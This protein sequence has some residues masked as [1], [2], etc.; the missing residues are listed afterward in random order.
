MSTTVPTI[1][2]AADRIDTIILEFI[3]S[4]PVKLFVFVYQSIEMSICGIVFSLP[5][6]SKFKNSSYKKIA[7]VIII[8]NIH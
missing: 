6:S 5:F 3:F 2:A 1:A 7:I 8:G 4:P